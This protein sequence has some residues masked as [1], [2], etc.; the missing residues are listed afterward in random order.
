M[1]RIIFSVLA[2]MFSVVAFA[3]VQE[4]MYVVDGKVIAPGDVKAVLSEISSKIETMSVIK[5]GVSI[6]KYKKYGDVSN[7]VVVILTKQEEEVFI[8]A[9]QMPKFMGGDLMTFRSWVMQNIRY[10]EA[11][12]NKKVEGQVVASFVVGKD[13]YIKLNEIQFLDECDKVLHDEVLRVFKTAPQWTPAVQ[14]GEN[15][16]VRFLL[17]IVFKIPENY[18]TV[19]GV[20]VVGFNE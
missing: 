9:E 15:V 10:P 13:G 2:M 11:A 18:N 3:H 12:L 6:E 19:P 4:P 20:Q 14:R 7:G 8:A 1:K 17:P 5:D 16:A